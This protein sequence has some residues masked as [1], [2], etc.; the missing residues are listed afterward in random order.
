MGKR[1]SI[2]FRKILPK[3][4]KVVLRQFAEALCGD[5]LEGKSFLC[6]ITG[7]S[8]LQKLNAGFLGH[9]YPTDV[10]SFPSGE[11]EQL[12]ELAISLERAI[13][14][15]ETHG[16]PV[17]DELKILMLHGVLHLSGL[18]HEQDR[19]QMR[20]VESKWRK[21]FGLASGLIERTT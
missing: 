2:L 10:L 9:D 17:L 18:D 7:D 12:G 11:S 21:H 8:E 20:R 15:A 1:A 16:H 6:L 4:D 19:G 14:Q 5:V 13:H 3:E